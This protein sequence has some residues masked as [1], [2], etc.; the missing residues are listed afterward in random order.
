MVKNRRKRG[1]WRTLVIE[2]IVEQ[3]YKSK[4]RPVKPLERETNIF[5]TSL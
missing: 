3:K 2:R 4:A 1:Y 5:K